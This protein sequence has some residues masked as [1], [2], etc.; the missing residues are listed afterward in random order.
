MIIKIRKGE[1]RLAER[2][3]CRTISAK[4]NGETMLCVIGKPQIETKHLDVIDIKHPFK[5]ASRAV[6]P[7]GTIIKIGDVTIGDGSFTIIAGPCSLEDEEQVMKIA[8]ILK[9]MGIKI[10]RAS[11]F[12][13]RTSP[14]SFQGLGVEGLKILKNVKKKTGLLVETEVMDVRD[15]RISAEY[16]DI[17]RVGARNMQNFDLLKEIGKVSI[18]VILKRG[19]SATIEEFLMSAEYIMAHGNSDVI[20]CERGI[21]TI[22]TKEYRNTLDIAAVPVIKKL[23]HL[24]V[25]IDPSHAAGNRD[26]V[27]PLSKAAAVI[28]ADGLLVEVHHDPEHALS[29]GA[30]SLYPEQMK[31][32]INSLRPICN[33]N[34]AKVN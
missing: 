5:L 12:K 17:I 30:Q 1:E 8:L 22:E 24:P 6:N 2:L 14:Y 3:K 7:N 19:L 9:D 23:S 31:E 29:D 32:L 21:R 20:L 13:P 26:L 34:G 16:V 15:V 25:I 4:I 10:L 28:G 33:I 18:P 11:V 27:I